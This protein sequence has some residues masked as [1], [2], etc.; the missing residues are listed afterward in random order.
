MNDH[1]EKLTLGRNEPCPCGSGKKYKRCC[2]VDAAPKLSVKKASPHLPPGIDP[3]QFNPDQLSPEWMDQF[4]KA[5]Q[6]LPKGQVQQFQHLMQKAMA[7]KN[8]TAEAEALEKL[9]PPDFMELAQNAPFAQN[10][11]ESQQAEAP[12]AVGPEAPPSLSVEE[13][14]KIIEEAAAAGKISQT[15]AT[16][17]LK[18]P[19]PEQQSKTS[20]FWKTITGKK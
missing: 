2:G 4:S 1:A 17:L 12:Q 15:Q 16:E 20:K 19:D 18:T 8:V 7:G 6:R 11:A 10:F 14:K 5:F 3:S 9:L 13:A